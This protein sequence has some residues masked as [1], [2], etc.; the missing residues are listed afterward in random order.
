MILT[1]NILATFVIEH[2]SK[3]RAIQKGEDSEVFE[4]NTIVAFHMLGSSRSFQ[5][6]YDTL[7]I[8]EIV[9]LTDYEG[10]KPRSAIVKF[11]T[12]CGTPVKSKV[13][14]KSKNLRFQKKIIRTY[15]PLPRRR[16]P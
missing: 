7:K 10:N 11:V 1:Q 13:K 5:R 2:F 9:R 6:C 4:E 15:I 12:L 3:R 14:V 8:G 16:Q